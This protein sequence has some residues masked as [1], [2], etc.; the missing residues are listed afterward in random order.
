MA[1]NG[2]ARAFPSDSQS[3]VY[4]PEPGMSIRLWLAG[5]ALASLAGTENPKVVADACL[6]YADAIL[7]RCDPLTP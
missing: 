3:I 4:G 6:A 5:Q 1:A 7:E 2:N